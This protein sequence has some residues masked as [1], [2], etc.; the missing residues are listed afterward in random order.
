MEN[1]KIK[2]QTQ[3]SEKYIM[4]NQKNIG[5]IKLSGKSQK[6]FKNPKILEKYK[7]SENPK[8]PKILEN[9]KCVKDPKNSKIC[10]IEKSQ[11]GRRMK[12]EG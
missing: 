3:K 9:T 12:D 1:L 7:M 2:L 10:K 11:I 4:K 5:N 6:K 8:N